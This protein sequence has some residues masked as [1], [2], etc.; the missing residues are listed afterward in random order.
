MSV[1]LILAVA[2][3]VLETYATGK[4]LRKL[5][6]IAKPAVMICLF[7]WLFFATGLQGTA[8]WFAMAVAFCLVGDV[9]LLWLDRIFI[10]GLA[11]FFLANVFY[12]IGFCSTLA[13]LSIWSVLIAVVL[14]L[15]AVRITRV[16]ISSLRGRK[17]AHLVVPV[18]IYSM[19]I[20]LTLYA[21]MS[22]TFDLSWKP[23]ASLLAAGGAFLFYLSDLILAWNRFVTT[24]KHGR[25][26]NIGLYQLGQIMMISGVITQLG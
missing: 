12:T 1:F 3:A 24:I 18:T 8:L 26:Y 15:S 11:A 21:A 14:A 17:L 5:E 19:V 16:I 6:F 2:V 7:L 4:G 9:L 22:T 23:G 25:V 20:S 10:Y 13:T